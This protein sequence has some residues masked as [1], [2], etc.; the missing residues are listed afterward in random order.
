MEL[1]FDNW[2][3]IY[4]EATEAAWNRAKQYADAEENADK[5][6]LLGRNYV[7]LAMARAYVRE[8][9]KIAIDRE[10]AR[11]KLMRG[12]GSDPRFERI[13]PDFPAYRRKTT[14]EDKLVELV[15]EEQDEV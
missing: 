5:V 2:E 11:P 8:E 6:R 1:T 3:R 4:F 12:W 7:I 13:Y 14:E 9:A 10:N 15:K